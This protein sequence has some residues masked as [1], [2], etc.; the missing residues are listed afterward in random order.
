VKSEV[1]VAGADEDSKPVFV[2]AAFASDEIGAVGTNSVG[3]SAR[4]VQAP[5]A[6]GVPGEATSWAEQTEQAVARATAAG[7]PETWQEAARVAAVVAEMAQTMQV[8]AGAAQVASQREEAARRAAEQ[9]EAAARKAADAKRDA[10]Q[11]ARAAEQTAAAAKR[12]EQAAAETKREA[13]RTAEEAPKL[14][15]AAKVAAQASADA[16]RKAQSLE[17]IVAAAS[18]ANT[19]AAWSEALK[20]LSSEQPV[21]VSES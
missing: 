14:D 21:L 1:A 8:A 15:Q 19:P 9:A 2:A 6:G 17:G 11:A 4:P 20:K 12:A 5:K 3:A 18:S 7:T 10:E 13:D 16:H